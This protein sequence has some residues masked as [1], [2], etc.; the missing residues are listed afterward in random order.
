MNIGAIFNDMNTKINV[1]KEIIEHLKSRDEKLA[2]VIDFIGEIDGPI[3]PDPFKGI[4]YHILG[5]QISVIVQDTLWDRLREK[6]SDEI[7]PKNI[8]KLGKDELRNLGM[9]N[10]KAETIYNIAEMIE[11]G[12]LDFEKLNLLSNE[13]FIKEITKLK[14][15]G[16]WTAE[17]L[18]MFSFDRDDVFTFGDVALN[19]G[20]K[21]IY[22]L[23]DISKEQF[24]Y[25]KELFSPYGTIASLYIW[26]IGEF[27]KE[28]VKEFIEELNKEEKKK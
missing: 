6:L 17:M 12:R 13:D 1:D 25:F 28:G 23:E 5:Q 22:G 9:T 14:G 18:L 27:K 3:E 4:V 11:D 8:I 16:K 10:R 21:M 15:I 19:R 26:G 2:K 7:T 24:E 20:L